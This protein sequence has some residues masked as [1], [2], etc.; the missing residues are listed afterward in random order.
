MVGTPNGPLHAPN[1]S[2]M[3]PYVRHAPIHFEYVWELGGVVAI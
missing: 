3:D 2:I 1:P